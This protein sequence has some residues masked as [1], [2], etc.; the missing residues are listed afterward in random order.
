MGDKKKRDALALVEA[1]RAADDALRA[2]SLRRTG[3]PWGQIAESLGRSIIEIQELVK[4]GYVQLLGQTDPDTLRAEVE[5]RYDSV[6]RQANIDLATASSITERNTVY[7]TILATEAAR[8]KLLGLA[9]RA[10][11]DDA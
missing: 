5:D 8:V 2:I 11:D 1:D 3:H 7:R 6:L 9:M 10:G 4:V